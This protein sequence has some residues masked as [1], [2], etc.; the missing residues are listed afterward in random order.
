[1]YGLYIHIPYCRQ[2]CH[3]CNFHF[4][5]NVKTKVKVIGAI[6]KEIEVRK[7]FLPN[8]QI[9]TIYFGGGTPSLLDFNELSE[10]FKTI[11]KHFRL[12]DT[13]EITLECNPE[14]VSDQKLEQW[15]SLGINR[16]SIGIQSFLDKDLNLMNRAHNAD[17][18]HQALRLI[19]DSNFTNVTADLMFGLIDSNIDEWEQNLDIMCSYKIPHLSIYNLTIE[20]QTVFAN[21]KMKNKLN[22]IPES[23]QEDQFHMARNKLASSGYE[24]YE[25]SNY[26]LPG[27]RALHNQNYWNRI[28]YLG[29]GPSAHSFYKNLR[30]SNIANNVLYVKAWETANDHFEA[31]LLSDEDV[32]N[33][34]IMLGLRR[35]EGIQVSDLFFNENS[36]K[37]FEE[38]ADPFLKAGTLIKS[39]THVQL[40]KDKW[41]LSDHV[42]SSLFLTNTEE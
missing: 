39:K 31:E 23:L 37:H 9:G 7:S 1:M 35:S 10:I 11:R 26:A 29:I 34:K 14:D 33:E 13:S 16:L 42:A 6:C 38:T 18:S 24:H 25:I 5:T 30:T 19:K 3:Y 12:A 28:P 17:Q 8:N 2:A 21:W 41:Y 20:E 36:R 22:V 15:W 40:H 32:Y 4:S 27:F